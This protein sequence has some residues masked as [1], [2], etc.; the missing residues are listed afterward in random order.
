MKIKRITS[1][2]YKSYFADSW[3][4]EVF[5]ERRNKGKCRLLPAATFRWRFER[6]VSSVS[7]DGQTV[8]QEW[9]TV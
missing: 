4:S 9:E 3:V 5:Y 6:E 2:T 7:R 8:F 1:F